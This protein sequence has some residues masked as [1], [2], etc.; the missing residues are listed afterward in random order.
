MT[1]T[2]AR[3]AVLA[4]FGTILALAGEAVVADS[5]QP[6]HSCYE[7]TKPTKPYSLDDE[8]EIDR[9]N[10]AIERYN[11]EVEDFRNC[12]QSFVD[13]QNEAI[14]QHR[15]AADDAVRAWNNFVNWN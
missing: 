9:Y 7:P 5:W 15:S 4:F 1:S 11:Y 14:R 6:S 13:E 12:I 10:S 3:L 8:W 2:T